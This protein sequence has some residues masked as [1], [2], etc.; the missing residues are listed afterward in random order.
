MAPL[1][2]VYACVDGA[3]FRQYFGYYAKVQSD[4]KFLL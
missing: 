1:R 4:I 2:D 3:D